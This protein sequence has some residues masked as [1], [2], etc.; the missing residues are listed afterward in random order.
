MGFATLDVYSAD[1]NRQR[2]DERRHAGRVCDEP[3]ET[4]E[5]LRAGLSRTVGVGSGIAVDNVCNELRG[6]V[7]E[8]SG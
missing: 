5:E 3:F 2:R 6:A 8:R 4:P 1:N 7:A